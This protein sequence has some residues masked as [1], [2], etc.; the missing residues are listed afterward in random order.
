M[1]YWK[2]TRTF[3][4]GETET[5]FTPKGITSFI[6]HGDGLTVIVSGTPAFS[7]TNKCVKITGLELCTAGDMLFELAPRGTPTDGE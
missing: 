1:D 6:A 2:I 5:L 7:A 4:L 3:A